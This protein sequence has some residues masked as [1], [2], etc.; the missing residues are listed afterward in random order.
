MNRYSKEDKLLTITRS[1]GSTCQTKP[2]K[3][4]RQ[5]C[6][7][8]CKNHGPCEHDFSGPVVFTRNSGSVT[9]RHCGM[10]AMSHDMEVSDDA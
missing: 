6:H 9:C 1:D 7:C 10:D 3:L 2:I 4:W 5:R 8:E